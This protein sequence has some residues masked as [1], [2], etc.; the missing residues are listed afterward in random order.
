M[1]SICRLIGKIGV[2]AL[3]FAL[4][5]VPATT[6][7][8]MAEEAGAQG[9]PGPG[10]MAELTEAELAALAVTT[11]AAFAALADAVTEGNSKATTSHHPS[12]LED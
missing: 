3:L 9:N 11:A 7:M 12:D 8:A 4:V 2:F 10:G 1:K 5:L 6:H